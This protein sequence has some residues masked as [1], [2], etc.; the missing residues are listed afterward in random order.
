MGAW[1]LYGR[2]LRTRSNVSAAAF[3][4]CI[5]ASHHERK[6]HTN[7]LQPTC[8]QHASRVVVLVASDHGMP[9]IPQSMADHTSRPTLCDGEAQERSQ[10][11]PEQCGGPALPFQGTA[12]LAALSPKRHPR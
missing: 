5:A 9:A 1:I 10:R 12:V 2:M 7:H 6:F 11:R 4:A 3:P 8:R